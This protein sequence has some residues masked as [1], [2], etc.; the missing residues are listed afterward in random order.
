MSS[1]FKAAFLLIITIGVPAQAQGLDDK[2]PHARD[3]APNMPRTQDTIP[4]RMRMDDPATTGSNGG[5]ESSPRQ[6]WLEGRGPKV[7]REARVV[8][9][10]PIVRQPT[11]KHS[12]IKLRVDA[13]RLRKHRGVLRRSTLTI[14]TRRLLCPAYS[15]RARRAASDWVTEAKLLQILV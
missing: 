4:D 12:M 11:L 5:A 1:G 14:P 15:G 13:V 6:A 2:T 9:A 3:A 8:D 7:A 10:P